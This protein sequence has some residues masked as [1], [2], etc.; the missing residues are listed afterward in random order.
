VG[1]IICWLYERAMR[2]RSNAAMAERF[3]VLLASGL[4]VG[5]SLLGVLTAGLIVATGNAAP[6][7]LVGDNFAGAAAWLGVL[8]FLAVLA[9]CYRWVSRQ[10]VLNPSAPPSS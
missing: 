4:I 8:L 1:A 7:A 10:S 2:G 3:G 9:I 6:L 5:E